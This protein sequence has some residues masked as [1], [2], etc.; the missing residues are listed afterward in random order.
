M[1]VAERLITHDA[2][3]ASISRVRIGEV[4]PGELLTQEGE[5][6]EQEEQEEGEHDAVVLFENNPDAAPEAII[7]RVRAEFSADKSEELEEPGEQSDQEELEEIN[8]RTLPRNVQILDSV[9]TVD[10][11]SHIIPFSLQ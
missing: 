1:E 11:F 10:D 8:I 2:P 5:E 4:D 3:Y 7:A 9:I 6:E